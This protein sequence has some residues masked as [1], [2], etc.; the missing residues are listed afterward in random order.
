[1]EKSFTAD[2]AVKINDADYFF[3]KVREHLNVAKS[4]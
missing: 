3:Q 4:A 1:M 2:N